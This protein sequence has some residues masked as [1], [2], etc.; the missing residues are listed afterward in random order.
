MGFHIHFPN[1]PYS[2]HPFRS[3]YSE[4]QPYY[5]WWP[6]VEEHNAN[7]CFCYLNK[8][9]PKFFLTSL[10]TQSSIPSP[11][12]IHAYPH[13]IFILHIDYSCLY[14]S[15]YKVAED[16]FSHLRCHTSQCLIKSSQ[17]LD[18]TAMVLHFYLAPLILATIK[19][20]A[21]H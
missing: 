18:N 20:S 5:I 12:L 10:N 15:P 9:L 4:A 13:S 21:P 17:T 19:L 6:V 11:L 3:T 14:Y 2:K 16:V 8:L 7:E 1:K